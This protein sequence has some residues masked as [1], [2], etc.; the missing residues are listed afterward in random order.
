METS[1]DSETRWRWGLLFKN[2]EWQVAVLNGFPGGSGQLPESFDEVL[3]DW[4]QIDRTLA[5]RLWPW[6]R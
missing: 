5:Q 6:P 3:N 1:R 4:Q 2:F